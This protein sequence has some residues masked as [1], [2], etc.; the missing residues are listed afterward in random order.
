[1]M[2]WKIKTNT[3][4]KVLAFAGSRY[5][6]SDVTSH[7]CQN[8]FSAQINSVYALHWFTVGLTQRSD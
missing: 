3:Q 2:I 1:M 8:L 4:I 5:N 7:Q 6:V